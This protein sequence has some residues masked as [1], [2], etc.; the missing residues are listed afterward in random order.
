[1]KANTGRAQS[2]MSGPLP[3][4]CL[5]A[6]AIVSAAFLTNV[7]AAEKVIESPQQP[8]TL[9]FYTLDNDHLRALP[10]G[11]LAASVTFSNVDYVSTLEPRDDE[12]YDFVFPGVSYDPANGSY[13]VREGR[14]R[15]PV[16]TV[17]KGLIGSRIK[18]APGARIIVKVKD[19]R[20]D[21]ALDANDHPVGRP[22]WVDA[23]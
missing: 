19:G 2:R 14:E 12:R 3:K 1:M 21:V 4:L 17:S 16:A 11:E 20:A 6:A 10:D 7:Q 18:L 15:I 23:Q 5:S 22:H 13:F 8:S 9:S